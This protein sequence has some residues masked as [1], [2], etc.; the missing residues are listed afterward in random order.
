MKDGP[1]YLLE[2]VQRPID[3]LYSARQARNESR[4]NQQMPPNRLGRARADPQGAAQVVELVG[5]QPAQRGGER[6]GGQA[7]LACK[8]R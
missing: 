4:E 8:A 5:Q 6:D 7:F 2:L 1:L 3:P